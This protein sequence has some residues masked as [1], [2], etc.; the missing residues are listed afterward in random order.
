M[1]VPTSQ[2]L[3]L[4]TSL[5]FYNTLPARKESFTPIE[6]GKV[7]MYVCGI[8]P[9]DESHLGHARCYVFFDVVRRYFKAAGYQ[10]LHVQNFTDIDDKIIARAA[11]LGK[12]PQALAQFYIDD[13]LV[14]MSLLN[15]L[16][17][18]HYPRATEVVPQIVRFIEK[19]LQKGT[20][21][22]LGGDVYYQVRRFKDY[23]KLSKQNLAEIESGARIEVDERKKDPLDFA[24]WKAAKPGE[25]SWESPW[26]PGR[27]GWHIECSVMAMELL[28]ESFDIHGGGQDLIFPHHENEI[29]QSEG[30]TGKPFARY[31]LHNGFVTVDREKMSKSLGNF[32][33]L[34]EIFAKADPEAV[35]F[36]LLSRHYKSP[37]DFSDELLLQARQA[38]ATLCEIN[39]SCFF[40]FGETPDQSEPLADWRKKC[41]EALSD[42]FNTEKAITVLFG[43]R[44]H[45][46][47][48]IK[49][50]D[51]KALEIHWQ[52]L[53][54]LS[55]EILGL[56]LTP[57]LSA[58]QV[59]KLKAR[60]SEREGARKNKDWARADAVRKEIED[61]GCLVEDT[62]LGSIVRGRG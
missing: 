25:P 31:W 46:A 21:Y 60:L 52:T 3:N 61:S 4:S 47:D 56:K 48:L 32:F 40:L 59:Q 22:V 12:T 5:Q 57:R 8:T 20:S 41:L 17:A 11:K 54:Y 62:P 29:A 19:L 1:N 26:G 24:L 10:I 49:K 35:R 30:L 9:Y 34:K 39:D 6:P 55:S 33:T 50:K 7:K 42:D 18:D 44:T 2:P 38:Y 43:L 23:G 36:L 15:V 27:P 45:M 14:K 16:P 13:Y 51:L 28:G 37:L 58:Q 53:K